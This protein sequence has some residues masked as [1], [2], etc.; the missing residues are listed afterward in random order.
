MVTLFGS[1]IKET[2]RALQ[3]RIHL[4]GTSVTKEDKNKAVGRI[5]ITCL[6]IFLAAYL[7]ATGKDP[8]AG[9]I[10]GAVVGY[11]IK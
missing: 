6:M 7:F 8:I 4:G 10:V 2:S 9:T 11:W 3:G 5:I 1:T